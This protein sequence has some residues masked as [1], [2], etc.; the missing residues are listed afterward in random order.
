VTALCGDNGAGKSTLVKMLSGATTPSTG[1]LEING[2]PVRFRSP[3]EAR[4][5]G[6]E[7]VFQDLGL[8]PHLTVTENVFL[9]R[10]IPRRGLLG[11]LGM[12]DRKAMRA[13]T[14]EAVRTVKINLPSL[15]HVVESMSGGQR[16]A[17][18]VSRTIAGQGKVVLLDEPTAA[19]GVRE[20]DRVVA[21]IRGLSASGVAVLLI[22]HDLPLVMDLSDRVIVLRHG[23]KVGDMA[24]AGRTV[25]DVIAYITGHR[26]DQQSADRPLI[27]S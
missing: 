15:E 1:T 11:R 23:E 3:R 2:R 12:M 25:E 6:V 26:T 14:A 27:R 22:S 21:L 5:A 24:V 10:E 13:A 8:A 4:Y 18:A 7:T 17:V 16:Q 20:T 19:L 9:G